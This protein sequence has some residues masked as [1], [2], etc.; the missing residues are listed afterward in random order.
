MNTAELMREKTEAVR[1]DFASN[2]EYTDATDF[3]AN[4]SAAVI[5]LVEAATKIDE[6]GWNMELRDALQTLRQ[7]VEDS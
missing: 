4:T 6:M 7:Q 5:G 1:S 2:D 3:L